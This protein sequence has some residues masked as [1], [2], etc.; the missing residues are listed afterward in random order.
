[1]GE[2]TQHMLYTTY[3]NNKKNKIKNAKIPF[4]LKLL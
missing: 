1:M 2:N 4:L 3:K